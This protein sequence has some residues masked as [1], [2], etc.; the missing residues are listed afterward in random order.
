V[1][2]KNNNSVLP[3]NK[4]QSVYIPK[5]YV[6]A[7][8][9]FFGQ[10]IPARW[11][12]PV[13]PAVAGK[14]FN[15]TDN[16]GEADVAVVVITNPINGRTAGYSTEAAGAGGNGFLPISLQ[17]GPYTATEARAESIAG[18]AR[19]GDVLNRSYKN[20]TVTADNHTDLKLIMD[21]KK[22]MRGKPVVVILKMSN[23]T[24]VAEFEKEIE[25]LL[26]N[27][28]VQDQ[29]VLDI[30]SGTVDPSGLLPLQMPANMATVERQYEDVPLDMEPHVDADG[31]TYDFGFGLNWSGKIADER[32]A[33][34]RRE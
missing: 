31:N 25:G 6:P 8:T 5:R 7:S 34:Y 26:L 33:R 19:E 22:A 23:P 11:E 15:V 27:F 13:N 12:D 17:Y 32:T 24:V 14:Y 9:T 1:I 29:A 2:L 4:E 18:D 16:P 20:K 21:T 28:N 30:L 3:I 10:E